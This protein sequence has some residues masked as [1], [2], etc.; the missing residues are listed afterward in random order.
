M[1]VEKGSGFEN[2]YFT[3]ILK[4]NMVCKVNL[5]GELAKKKQFPKEESLSIVDVVGGGIVFASQSGKRLSIY[6]T[7]F[8]KEI[9]VEALGEV[10][11]QAYKLKGKTYY[12]IRNKANGS[13][14]VYDQKGKALE[15]EPMFS[16]SDIAL[17]YFA[18]TKSYK[19]FF[20]ENN[21]LKIKSLVL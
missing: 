13:L 14:T 9:E 5:Y 2:T 19:L 17:L 18:K 15:V 1:F 8:G 7:N 20:V 4:G 10:K 6:N 12:F 16:S 21:K 3:S 11:V